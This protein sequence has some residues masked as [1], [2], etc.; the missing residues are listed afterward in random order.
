M[1]T[2]DF[3]DCRLRLSPLASCLAAAL[4]LAS[5]AAG[6]AGRLPQALD[7]AAAPDRARSGDL[8]GGWKRP[9]PAEI[10][11]RWQ[12]APHEIP[13]V[14][15]NSIVVQNCNDSGNGSLR[16]A[17]NN[18]NSGD[19]IDL[20]Q[21]SCSTITLTTGSLLF[22]ETTITLQGPGS[23]Y[24]SIRRQRWLTPHCCTTAPARCTSTI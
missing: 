8:P 12:P 15:A 7:A 22:T 2:T 18:A 1:G 16:D 19:T 20:T 10:A 13:P 6:A 5:G 21:L 3:A 17:L 23:K 4:A 9:D 14:P 11:L 24:L